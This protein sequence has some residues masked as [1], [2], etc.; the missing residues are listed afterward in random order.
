MITFSRTFLITALASITCIGYAE[1]TKQPDMKE[2]FAQTV[3][4]IKKQPN[5]QNLMIVVHLDSFVGIAPM[6]DADLKKQEEQLAKQL[7]G[8]A[9][10][11]QEEIIKKAFQQRVNA[12]ILTEP[13]I[14]DCVK[15]LQKLN[16]KVIAITDVMPPVAEFITV[17]LKQLGL[18]FTTSG[19]STQQLS[20][21]VG[22]NLQAL[23]KNGILFA[24]AMAFFEE[25]LTGL[26]KKTNNT[27]KQILFIARFA[28]DAEITEDGE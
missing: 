22:E 10:K 15:Q 26:L 6:T 28:E 18:D 3:A 16:I 27:K 19:I 12:L 13:A 9:S 17:R 21:P 23:Y 1:T 8:K 14:V 2:V 20:I 5:K 24:G 11:E 7:A 4:A 25:A